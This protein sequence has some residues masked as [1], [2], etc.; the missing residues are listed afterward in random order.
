MPGLDRDP[1]GGRELGQ[2]LAQQPRLGPQ[3][4]RELQQHRP[5]LAGKPVR[6]GHQPAHR[7]GRLAQPPHVGEIAAGLHGHDE[8]GGHPLPPAREDLPRGQPV[9]G[10][11][12]LHG[13]EVPGVV[14]EPAPLRH[15]GR[16]EDATPVP[17]LPA[18]RPGHNAHRPSPRFCRLGPARPPAQRGK[19]VWFTRAPE[20]LTRN[21]VS[22]S[23][24]MRVTCVHAVSIT[25]NDGAP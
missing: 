1:D 3:V 8:V 17:V 24:K 6:R 19:L 2:A 21:G 9:K 10:A 16:V 20:T 25:W 15:T 7:V 12:V 5:E 11:V 14:L 13:G 22:R 23:G 18:R 4:R